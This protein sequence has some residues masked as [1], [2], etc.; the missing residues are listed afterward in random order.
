[1]KSLN[2]LF[3]ETGLSP[4]NTFDKEDLHSILRSATTEALD[5][6][7]ENAVEAF[8]NQV[9]T[10]VL[11]GWKKHYPHIEHIDL[12]VLFSLELLVWPVLIQ[13]INPR[14]DDLVCHI[15][16]NDTVEGLTFDESLFNRITILDPNSAGLLKQQELGIRIDHELA[17]VIDKII[18]DKVQQ[19][20]DQTNFIPKLKEALVLEIEELW[21]ELGDIPFDENKNLELILTEPWLHFGAGT[22]REEIWRWFDNAHPEGLHWLMFKEQ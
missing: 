13:E 3:K 19:F 18:I 8:W 9:N 11:K 12:N 17:T 5:F 22:E 6:N 2:K 21:N 14:R 16:F 15:H 10:L 20:V 7:I 4:R 1:M